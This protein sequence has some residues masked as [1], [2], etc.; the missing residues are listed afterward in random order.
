MSDNAR[1][2]NTKRLAE[3]ESALIALSEEANGEGAAYRRVVNGRHGFVAARSK[4][5]EWDLTRWGVELAEHCGCRV[6][7][8]GF[9]TDEELAQ[10]H[11]DADTWSIDPEGFPMPFEGSSFDELP[12]ALFVPSGWSARA[13]ELGW[14]DSSSASPPL[15][16]PQDALG[17]GVEA[18]LRG[19]I[20]RGALPHT[21]HAA[22]N[23]A[24][25]ES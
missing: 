12:G 5:H 7:L 22:L 4:T 6:K 1:S 15:S 11:L 21:L 8:L 24:L 2:P 23:R 18:D 13:H 10:G 16:Q 25:L 3:V 20:A 19:W 9:G 17:T 14:T